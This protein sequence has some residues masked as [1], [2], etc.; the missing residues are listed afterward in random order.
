MT[1]EQELSE[2]QENFVIAATATVNKNL[3]DVMNSLCLIT[4]TDV[5]NFEKAKEFVI[6]TYTDV[7]QYRPLI[8]K[9]VSV[10]N[11]THFPTADAKYW[12]C[13][14]EAEVHFNEFNRDLTKYKKGLIDIAEIDYKIEKFEN[15]ITQNHIDENLDTQLIRF[16]IERLKVKKEQYLFEMKQ[17]EKTMKYRMEEVNDW[18]KISETLTTECEFDP[19]KHADH[20]TKSFI[21]GLENKVKKAKDENERKVFSAQLETFQRIFSEKF[22]KEVNKQLNRDE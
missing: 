20:Y 22:K 21:K 19:H 17:L 11:D 18:Y 13:K 6:S 3:M 16:D 4:P 12:Q 15:D 8:T 14:A 10:L 5:K 2:P 1:E 7:P 9:V